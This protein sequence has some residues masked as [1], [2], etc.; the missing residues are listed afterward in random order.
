M[1]LQ[2][3]LGDIKPSVLDI[4]GLLTPA[5]KREIGV[6][7][8]PI[9]YLD[10]EREDAVEGL[11]EWAAFHRLRALGRIGALPAAEWPVL[12]DAFKRFLEERPKLGAW[13]Q[14]RGTG[15]WYRRFNN[16]V[17]GNVW[18]HKGRRAVETH[19]GEAKGSEIL[20]TVTG[21]MVPL[22]LAIDR[23]LSYDWDITSDL[24]GDFYAEE[25]G[26]RAAYLAT[27]KEK[28]DVSVH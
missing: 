20:T 15:A 22:M 18:E 8:I 24:P 4:Q 25:L 10:G 27:K 1:Y 2:Q 3:L 9:G 12:P 16:Y 5:L 26:R 6:R 17:F 11:A 7:H 14:F 23:A 21:Q 13:E 19:K 28:F